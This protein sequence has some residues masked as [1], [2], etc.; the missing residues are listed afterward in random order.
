M[1]SEALSTFE[2]TLVVDVDKLINTHSFLSDS[3]R[4]RRGLGH[5]TRS[6]VVMLCAAWEQYMESVLL[7]SLKKMIDST[8]SPDNIP[9][10]VKRYLSTYVKE[11]KHELKP[12]E[13]AGDGWVNLLQ[14]VAQYQVDK[15]NTPKKEHLDKLFKRFLGIE[16]I[17]DSWDGTYPDLDEFV[18]VRGDIAHQGSGANY[19]KIPDLIS[20]RDDIEKIIVIVDNYLADHLAEYHQ[21]NNGRYKSPWRRR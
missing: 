14:E 11:S 4:G 9:V 17:S 21:T 2:K 15:L 3:G 5:I 20:Y 19:V 6:G 13:L 8:S 1:P 18:G 16:S 10:P 7:E 12:F